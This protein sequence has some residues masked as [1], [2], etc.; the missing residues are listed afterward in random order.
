MF[1]YFQNLFLKWSKKYAI[2]QI[3]NVRKKP[4][5]VY[6]GRYSYLVFEKVL[7]GTL[8]PDSTGIR[9]TRVGSS[10]LCKLESTARLKTICPFWICR[11]NVFDPWGTSS[12]HFCLLRRKFFQNILTA[13]VPLIITCGT[14]I[15]L[16]KWRE[17]S[18]GTNSLQPD[19]NLQFTHL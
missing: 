10:R 1:R 9:N 13:D 17:N 8:I 14:S 11:A 4:R 18:Q 7:P 3:F 12:P 19:C 6:S 5:Y 2:Y 16:L 15:S